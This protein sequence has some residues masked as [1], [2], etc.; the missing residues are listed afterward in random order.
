MTQDEVYKFDFE[1]GHGRDTIP[2][3]R[4]LKLAHAACEWS[5]TNKSQDLAQVKEP[6]YE[7]D[8]WINTI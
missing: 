3:E 2:Q 5:T 7:L 4:T 1:P 6:I 8:L